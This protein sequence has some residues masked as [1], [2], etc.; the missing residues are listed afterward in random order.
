MHPSII[1]N[2]T[3]G[4]ATALW[5][6]TKTWPLNRISYN[7][8]TVLINL[9]LIHQISQLGKFQ[10]P[11]TVWITS[12][13]SKWNTYHKSVQHGYKNCQ[14]VFWET[15][16]NSFTNALTVNSEKNISLRKSGMKFYKKKKKKSRNCNQTFRLKEMLEEGLNK[17]PQSSSQL[18][19][20]LV[21]QPSHH[22]VTQCRFRC[23]QPADSFCLPIM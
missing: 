6:S 3:I 8:K 12:Y 17:L 1:H 11:C 2:V 7:T 9:F 21:I 22:S 13:K 5:K 23:Q 19:S 18:L 15:A 4:Q 16:S 20:L 14:V 10:S